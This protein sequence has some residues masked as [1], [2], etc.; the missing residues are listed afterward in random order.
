MYS[1][2]YAIAMEDAMEQLLT[3][4]ATV[5]HVLRRWPTTIPVFI[6]HRMACVGC[7]MSAFE[8]LKDAASIYGLDL[9]EFLNELN[10]AI[11]PT[12]VGPQEG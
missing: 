10:R 4:D 7:S 1:I 3:P 8:T 5:A 9:A 2:R 11:R 6:R 12:I